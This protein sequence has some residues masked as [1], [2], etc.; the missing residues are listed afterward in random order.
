VS[1]NGFEE[2][3][4]ADVCFEKTAFGRETARH[5]AV[6]TYR[7]HLPFNVADESGKGALGEEAP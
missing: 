7:D 4:V 6:G 2:K 5:Q 3:L 1:W